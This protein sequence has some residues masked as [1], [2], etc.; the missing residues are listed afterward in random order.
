MY[1]YDDWQLLSEGSQCQ[2][3]LHSQATPSASNYEL[4]GHGSGWQALAYAFHGWPSSHRAAVAVGIVM[5]PVG[6]DASARLQTNFPTQTSHQ[7]L[8]RRSSRP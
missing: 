1:T 3:G 2:P 5:A 6:V 4:Q 8:G 7:R